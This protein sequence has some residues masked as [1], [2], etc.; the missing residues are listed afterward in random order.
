[1]ARLLPRARRGFIW[2]LA[3]GVGHAELEKNPRLQQKAFMARLV[4]AMTASAQ[5]HSY[6]MPTTTNVM[7]AVHLLTN[8]EI[9]SIYFP[10]VTLGA[11]RRILGSGDVR[12]KDRGRGQEDARREAIRPTCDASSADGGFF[13]LFSL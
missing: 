2:F 7:S 4:R 1:M 6:R 12:Q 5:G 11:T 13:Y 10:V 9:Y 8:S 3:V